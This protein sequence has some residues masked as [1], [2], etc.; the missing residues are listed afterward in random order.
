MEWRSDGTC[1]CP[2]VTR[3]TWAD[4]RE[5]RRGQQPGQRSGSWWK[6]SSWHEDDHYCLT[7]CP[8]IRRPRSSGLW[9]WRGRGSLRS[10]PRPPP[11]GQS[12]TS[13]SSAQLSLKTGH[14][15]VQYWNTHKVEAVREGRES[16]ITVRWPLL[17]GEIYFKTLYNFL[18]FSDK[19]PA[20]QSLKEY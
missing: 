19:N 18:A 7:S 4:W 1:G 14:H 15:I 13:S 2:F 5:R 6:T 17:V 11:R 3:K 8:S 10:E 16:G 20:K 9:C 12:R